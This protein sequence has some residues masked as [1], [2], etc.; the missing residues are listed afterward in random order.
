M[1]ERTAGCRQRKAQ[2]DGGPDLGQYSQIAEH[3]GTHGCS[4]HRARSGE[5]PPVE[6]IDRMGCRQARPAW[7]SFEPGYQ[8]QVVVRAHRQEQDPAM[9][10]NDPVQVNAQLPNTP[11]LDRPNDAPERA[12]VP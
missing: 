6:A 8:Q 3:E 7:I 2:A 5:L 12:T 11:G 1:N 9:A 10:S 4:E